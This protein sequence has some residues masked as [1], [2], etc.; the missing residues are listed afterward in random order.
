MP[1]FYVWDA[2]ALNVSRYF[3]CLCCIYH[4]N[5]IIFDLMSMLCDLSVSVL[6]CTCCS[7]LL[8]NKVLMC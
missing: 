3:K 5:L 6:P 2:D 4:V 8:F 1:G 7:N